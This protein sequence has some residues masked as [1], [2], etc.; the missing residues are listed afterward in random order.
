VRRRLT[1]VLVHGLAVRHRPET[2]LHGVVDRLMPLA[3]V[4]TLWLRPTELIL[5]RLADTGDGIVPAA[6]QRWQEPLGEVDLDHAESVLLG[7]SD[8]AH[9]RALAT[10]ERMARFALGAA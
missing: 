1:L 9:E 8:A 5:G 3:P 4:R 2:M 10:W 7:S 6:T